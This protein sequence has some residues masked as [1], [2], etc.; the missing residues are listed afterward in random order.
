MELIRDVVWLMREARLARQ[1][2]ASLSLSHEPCGLGIGAINNLGSAMPWPGTPA[3][4]RLP[5][6]R[7]VREQS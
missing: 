7:I 4:S 2:E 5:G 3:L 1:R 6:A